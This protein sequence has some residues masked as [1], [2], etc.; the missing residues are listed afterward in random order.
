MGFERPE[1]AA[2]AQEFLKRRIPS[3]REYSHTHTP[4]SLPPSLPVDHSGDPTRNMGF[5]RP[6]HVARAEEFLKRR[7]PLG[8]T[9]KTSRIQ[10]EGTGQG[11]S[12]PAMVRAI[13]ILVRRGDLMERD[14]GRVLKRVR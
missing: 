4:P 13:S 1:H 10:E 8:S 5:E 3:E 14:Q 11:Y 12:H 9:T 6:E 2:R 7:I